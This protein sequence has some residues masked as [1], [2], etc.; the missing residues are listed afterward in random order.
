MEKLEK[1]IALALTVHKA[2]SFDERSIKR[3]CSFSQSFKMKPT[4][5]IDEV[6]GRHSCQK[7]VNKEGLSSKLNI[8]ALRLFLLEFVSS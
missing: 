3:L 7:T 2:A 5:E 1:S 6:N 8:V 4:G